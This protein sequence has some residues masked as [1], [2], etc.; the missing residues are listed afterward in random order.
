M[1]VIECESCVGDLHGS[2]VL[3]IVL[4]P[5]QL[6]GKVLELEA[7]LRQAHMHGP[8]QTLVEGTDVGSLSL[9]RL[10]QVQLQIRD[11]LERV[12]AV[13]QRERERESLIT[14]SGSLAV[15]ESLAEL[16]IDWSY[17]SLLSFVEY[18]APTC[19]ALFP[20]QRVS[21]LCANTALPALCTL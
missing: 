7:Q 18:S 10:E 21:S 12:E 14:V 8:L 15:S 5:V 2:G 17:L 4:S 1:S 9:S 19:N 20:V 6:E 16:A 3:K 13:S 11:D